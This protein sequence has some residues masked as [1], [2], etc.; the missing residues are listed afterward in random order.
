M[1]IFQ[2]FSHWNYFTGLAEQSNVSEIMQMQRFYSQSQRRVDWRHVVIKCCKLSDIVSILH[3]EFTA[4]IFIYRAQQWHHNDE[5]ALSLLLFIMY[6]TPISTMISSLSLNHHLY[7]DDTKLFFS[8]YASDLDANITLLR[9]ALQHIFSWMT[10][11]LLTLNASK[12]EFLLIG[13]NQQLP[14][15]NDPLC[16]Q[17]WH[18]LRWT[19]HFLWLN[20]IIIQILLFSHPCISLYPSVS[21]LQNCQYYCHVYRSLQTWVMQFTILQSTKFSN[22]SISTSQNSLA[23]TV[24]KFPRFSHIT[25]VIKSLHW[26][27]VKERIEYKLLSLTFKVFT[28]SQPTY[29]SKLVTVQSPRST[30]SSSVVTISRPPNSSYLKICLLYTSPSPRD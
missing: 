2:A 25:P 14:D 22:K 16:S 28:T 4:D 12:T 5:H 19:S 18:N 6:T 13:L 24:V 21:W 7:A 8:F 1:K 10:A 23:R 9:N 15:R 26:L 29:L 17:T 11:N 3:F 27:N 20:I 30:R